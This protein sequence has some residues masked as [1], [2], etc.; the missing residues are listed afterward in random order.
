MKHLILGTAGH[1]D[2]GKTALIKALTD[3]DCDTHK[4]EKERGITINLGFSH[5]TLPSGEAV[6]I[7]DVPGHKDFIKTM[8]AGAFGIDIVLLVVAADSGVMPQT[9]EHLQIIDMLGVKHGIVVL[10]KIDLV[11]DEM[12]ELAEMEIAEFLEGTS[13]ENAP[14]VGVSSVTGEGLD[15]LIEKI[16]EIIPKIEERKSTD[17]FRMYIDRIFNVKGIGF[18]VTGSVLEGELKTGKEL[19]L[20]PG[21]NKKVKV[22]NI[23]R[24][25]EPT[26]KVFSGDRAA[27][28]LAGLKSEDYKRGMVLC[29]KQIEETTMIDA[30]Y[31]LFDINY[32]PGIWSKVLFY[33]GTF[34]CGA[35]IHLLDKDVLKAGET[36]I[37]QI[38][39]EKPAILVNGD[40]FIIRNSSNDMTLGGG[41]V[42]DTTPL[43]HRK[44]TPVLIENLKNL[45]EA[46]INSDNLFNLI[47]IELKKENAPVF[48]QFIAGKLNK[49]GDEIVDECKN[50]NDGSVYLFQ[51]SEKTILIDKDIHKEYHQKVLNILKEEHQKYPILEEGFDTKE[52][53]GKFGFTKNDAGKSYVDMLMEQMLEEGLV[54]RVGNSFALS[55]HTV[56][57]DNKTQEQ[58]D[59]LE[60]VLEET[61]IDLP[62]FEK[63]ENMALHR[64]IKKERLKMLLKYLARQNKLVFYQGE[65]LHKNVV[66]RSRKILLSDLKNKELGINEK[67]FRLL[68]NTTKKFIQ[69]ILGILIEEGTVYKKTFYILLTDKGKEMTSEI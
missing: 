2:H 67:E 53:Y 38:H 20:L 58:L 34:E 47:K 35:K 15:K 16:T 17:Y 52:F 8:V 62:D 54:K 57:I 4:E 68:L 14:I 59:W 50:N 56:T 26:E 31:T 39:L 49:T 55:D 6:G 66:D 46:T 29:D 64:K 10:N 22:R 28:N 41:V 13:F 32:E 69:V 48:A 45:V 25:G 19:F 43:H 44:R 30:T 24:H 21:K 1:V 12:A 23:E 36:A 27:I 37:V 11:D 18:V 65:Y 33:S 42:I 7:V 9:A 63:I 61:G 5:L 3:I 51:H 40:R 60:N